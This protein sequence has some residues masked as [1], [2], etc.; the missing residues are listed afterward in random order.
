MVTLKDAKMEYHWVG[1]KVALR[2][3]E[4]VSMRVEMTVCKMVEKMAV[5]SVACLGT[6]QVV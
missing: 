2:G 6:K 5:R 3:F 1:M 4:R